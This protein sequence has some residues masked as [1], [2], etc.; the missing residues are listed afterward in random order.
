MLKDIATRTERC[1]HMGLANRRHGAS[2]TT[3][4]SVW[5]GMRKRCHYSK[6]PHYARYGGRG[7][8]VCA[9][10]SVFENFFSDMGPRPSTSHTLDRINNDG[11]YEPS[12]CRWATAIEQRNNISTNRYISHNGERLTTAQWAHRVGIPPRTLRARL[13]R[14]WSIAEALS[15]LTPKYGDHLRGK[16][17]PERARNAS[18]RAA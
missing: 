9:R 16:Q 5:L 6:H 15:P 17:R 7:I 13:R 10:W 11:N 8:K 3:E 1:R 12:N 4:Y 14:G 18:G 2:H